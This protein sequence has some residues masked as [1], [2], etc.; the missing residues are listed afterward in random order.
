[1]KVIYMDDLRVISALVAH[2][3]EHFGAELDA[4]VVITDSSTN[5][6]GVVKRDEMTGDY[7][8]HA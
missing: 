7:A 5:P 6:I 8:F 1:M 2:L 4:E 3:N